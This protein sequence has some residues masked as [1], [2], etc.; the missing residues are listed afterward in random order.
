MVSG[1]WR[2]ASFRTVRTGFRM[3][4]F[5]ER[6]AGTAGYQPQNLCELWGGIRRLDQRGQWN[7][8]G[9][10][11]AHIDHLAAM[12]LDR[13]EYWSRLVKIAGQDDR[14]ER[15]R[16]ERRIALIF[17]EATT[18]S[19]LSNQIP[20]SDGIVVRYFFVRPE[21]SQPKASTPFRTATDIRKAQSIGCCDVRLMHLLRDIV[22][23]LDLIRSV[24]DAMGFDF[25]FTGQK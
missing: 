12:V 14:A 11:V 20:F 15:C 4:T 19:G 24:R 7:P 10:E 2:G 17:A 16:T 13:L 9:A 5:H 23:Q 25:N 3:K 22:S 18:A 1:V 8:R 21:C 6:A